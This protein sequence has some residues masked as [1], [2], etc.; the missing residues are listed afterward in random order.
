VTFTDSG[1]LLAVTDSARYDD[2]NGDQTV[3]IVSTADAL[4]G[5]PALIGFLPAGAFPRQFGGVPG[6]PLIF[7]DFNSYDIRIISNGDLRW[8]QKQRP[9]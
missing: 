7:T 8:L 9:S 4:A 3:A 6:G 2:P 5:R 1:T